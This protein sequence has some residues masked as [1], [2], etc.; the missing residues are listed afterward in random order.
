[1]QYVKMSTLFY[2]YGFFD[3]IKNIEL[4]IVC[5]FG[6]DLMLLRY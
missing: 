3:Q 4:Y 6:M 1:M 2:S 5:D